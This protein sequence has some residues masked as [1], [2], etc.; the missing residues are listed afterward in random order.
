MS[1]GTNWLMNSTT[2]QHQTSRTG[3]WVLNVSYHSVECN[4][5]GG[6]LGERSLDSTV[7]VPG[8]AVFSGVCFLVLCGIFLYLVKLP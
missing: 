4:N 2:T 1:P 6:T 8:S 7:V 3:R 5:G